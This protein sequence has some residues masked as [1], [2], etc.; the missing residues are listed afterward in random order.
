MRVLIVGA[1][2]VGQ[3]Y[4]HHLARGGA[5]V[6]F[7]VK[8]KY[9][10]EVARGSTLYQL[11]NTE[12][13]PW[14]PRATAAPTGDYDAVILTVS[15]DA[16]RGS[17]WLVELARK[18]GDATVV[19][20]QPGLDD[21]AY[22][23]ERVEPTRLVDGA[24]HFLAYHAPLPGETRFVSPGVAYWLFPGKGPFSGEDDARCDAIVA[25]L[26]AGDMP[27]KRVRDTRRGSAFASVVLGAFIAALEAA[28][29]SFASMR[30]DGCLELG[31]RAARESLAVVA[32]ERTASPPLG[33]KLVARS[34]GFRALLALAPLVTPVELETYL[35]VHFTKVGTQMHDNL[36]ALVE[37]GR[38]AG[39][40][41]EA[42]DALARRVGA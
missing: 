42:L 38:R 39:L 31:A 40:P 24:I 22:V 9:L 30:R 3:V 16:L 41:I 5:D 4:G 12:P 14:S 34:L 6:T 35:Q 25:A 20:L 11:P 15:S 32:H 28:G 37:H 13:E 10:E 33:T 1:G 8:P 27:V 23:A 17:E 36:R 29:W 7:L 2:A 26:A 18:T 21:R 19:V